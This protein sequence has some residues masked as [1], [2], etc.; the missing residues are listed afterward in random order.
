MRMKK[1]SWD[2]AVGVIVAS[3]VVLIVILT[4]ITLTVKLFL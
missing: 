4:A 2:P 3:L 1:V